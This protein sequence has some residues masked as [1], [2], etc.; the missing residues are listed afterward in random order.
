[1]REKNVGLVRYSEDALMPK[2]WAIVSWTFCRTSLWGG[3][4]RHPGAAGPQRILHGSHRAMQCHSTRHGLR[5]GGG[6]VR[7]TLSRQP[8]T[9]REPCARPGTE[10]P[11]LAGM[12][13][14]SGGTHGSGSSSG[15]ERPSAQDTRLLVEGLRATPSMVRGWGCRPLWAVYMQLCGEGLW[16]TVLSA[17]VVGAP[18]CPGPPLTSER[19]GR[20]AAMRDRLTHPSGGHITCLPTALYTCTHVDLPTYAPRTC[21]HSSHA[22]NVLAR[23]HT[24]PRVRSHVGLPMNY[25]H[26]YG[27][28]SEPCLGPQTRRLQH[29]GT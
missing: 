25:A 26:T 17:S 7:R 2:A 24:R 19:P 23:H 18:P 4:T 3:H 14:L 11:L 29:H 8:P 27:T 20:R 28:Y 9:S 12:A 10:D 5:G 13:T 6:A 16:G 1:M 15:G 22:Q 21:T